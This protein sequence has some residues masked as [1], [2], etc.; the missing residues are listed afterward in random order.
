MDRKYFLSSSLSRV[1]ICW[2]PVAQA[3]NPS[4]SGGRDQEDQGSKPAWENSSQNPISKNTHHKKGL[5]EWLKVWAL[6]ANPS[7]TKKERVESFCS[8]G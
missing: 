4:F 5:A 3:Y 1:A 8:Q 6:S 7:T 2:G